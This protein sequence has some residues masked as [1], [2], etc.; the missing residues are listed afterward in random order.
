MSVRTY[1]M[2]VQF[3][4]TAKPSRVTIHLDSCRWARTA[5]PE[6]VHHRWVRLTGER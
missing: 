5:V 3:G 6:S 2:R 1:V 4:N